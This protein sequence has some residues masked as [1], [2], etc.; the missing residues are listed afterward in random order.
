MRAKHGKNAGKNVFF[1][2]SLLCQQEHGLHPLRA[3]PLPKKIAR[4]KTARRSSF[5]H[6]PSSGP[7][8]SSC[9]F[10]NPTSPPTSGLVLSSLL[11][12]QEARLAMFAQV[13]LC[14][15]GC[16]SLLRSLRCWTITSRNTGRVRDGSDG[17]NDAVGERGF[18]KQVGVDR[19]IR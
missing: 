9:E 18:N 5:K 12:E 4:P 3:A 15:R 19:Q 17:T 1:K 13:S 10:H 16:R 7:A 2:S 8:S 11:K 6:L 14:S